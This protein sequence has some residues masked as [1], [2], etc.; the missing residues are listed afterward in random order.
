M[1]RLSNVFM[2]ASLMACSNA[3]QTSN[4]QTIESKE[5]AAESF[6]LKN[7]TPDTNLYPYVGGLIDGTSTNNYRVFCS[8]TL[9]SPTI[10]L[11]A[12]HCI[13]DK[14][15]AT[16]RSTAGLSFTNRTNYK[17]A[18]TGSPIIAV[19]RIIINPGYRAIS[20]TFTNDLAF[21]KLRSP[22][23]LYPYPV[24][25]LKQLR[26][27]MKPEV[28]L[29]GY[30]VTANS[31]D[32]RLR[33]Y[34]NGYIQTVITYDSQILTRPGDQ[35]QV[36]CSGDSGSPLLQS[37]YSGPFI[38]QGVLATANHAICDNVTANRYNG[39]YPHA[40]WIANSIKILGGL[41]PSVSIW[42]NPNYPTDVND[43]G[44]LTSLDALIIINFLNLYGPRT[45]TSAD[46]PPSVI[47][48]LDVD[49]NGVVSSLD[50]VRVINDLNKGGNRPR[51]YDQATAD[52]AAPNGIEVL[53][54]SQAGDTS[55]VNSLMNDAAFVLDTTINMRPSS[56]YWLNYLGLNEKWI[57]SDRGWMIITAEGNLYEYLGT[58]NGEPS[59]AIKGFF[60]YR[61]YENPALLASPT[62]P[63][64][65]RHAVFVS[66]AS[67]KGNLGGLS[68]A[69]AKCNALAQAAGLGAGWK[70]ILSDSQTDAK[71]RIQISAPVYDLNN[72][73]IAGSS[74]EFWSGAIKS[75]IATNEF[76]M[77][78]PIDIVFTGTNANGMRN[79]N[80][81]QCANWTSSSGFD[82]AQVGR[83]DAKDSRWIQLYQPGTAPSH[84]CSNLTRLYCIK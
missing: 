36:A 46:L 10:V 33:R 2:V 81:P 16:V 6:S 57:L 19:D 83:S 53:N 39:F 67:Y 50:A 80:S 32:T 68:G 52:I 73:L 9:I 4:S 54:A 79:T 84:A 78:S 21:L 70:A 11:T 66:S 72:T 5:V 26:T 76:K 30:G 45:L 69:D 8:G 28:I 64:A 59:L 61:M 49:G 71:S 41:P 40:A 58:K 25:N 75:P 42:Q 18:S 48:Y 1:R 82:G 29:T 38:I 56:N 27:D 35:G 47:K 22:I 7:G 62:P 37:P 13:F 3:P 34:A 77:G 31:A 44:Y 14:D 63:I 74:Q 20:N 15:L 65:A 43:D 55:R 12:A 51:H 17:D 60:D 24:M 23:N